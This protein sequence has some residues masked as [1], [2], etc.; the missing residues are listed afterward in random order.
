MDRVKA[1]RISDAIADALKQVEKDFNV[2]LEGRRPK[3]TYSTTDIRVRFTLVEQP[4]VATKKKQMTQMHINMVFGA[5]GIIKELG[6]KFIFYG[7]TYK[8]T[9]LTFGVRSFP[10]SAERDDGKQF[11]FSV[12]DVN[13]ADVAL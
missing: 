2:K 11:K 13:C 7:H 3:S 6:T 4:A 5:L 10:V 8:I 9:G 1:N 12:S